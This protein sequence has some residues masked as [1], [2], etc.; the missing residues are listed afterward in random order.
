MGD[1]LNDMIKSAAEGAASGFAEKIPKVYD[2]L[3]KP[4]AVELGKGIAGAI[5]LALSPITVTVWGFDRIGEWLMPKLTERLANM[6]EQNL[7]SPTASI[8]GPSIEAIRFLDN[9]P[10]LRDMFAELIAKA[11]NRETAN[12]THPG[13]VEIIKNMS[14]LDGLLFG[15][16]AKNETFRYLS[17][18]DPEGRAGEL[19][20]IEPLLYELEQDIPGYSTLLIYNSI[21]NLTRLGLINLHEPGGALREDLDEMLENNPKYKQD[22]FVNRTLS[23]TH[24]VMTLSSFGKQFRNACIE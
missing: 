5:K 13:F 8:V 22:I 4:G 24:T 16:L 10:V 20:S 1:E 6:P 7:I 21:E 2:D 17:V 18:Y 23:Y 12:Q 3:I 9:E 15:W 11:M 19:V 14:T